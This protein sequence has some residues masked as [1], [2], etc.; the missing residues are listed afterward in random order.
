MQTIRNTHTQNVILHIG[1][2]HTA[3]AVN[4]QRPGECVERQKWKKKKREKKK[5][6]TTEPHPALIQL[7]NEKQREP[8]KKKKSM[9]RGGQRSQDTENKDY[10]N[11][12]GWIKEQRDS[13]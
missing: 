8:K 11:T 3:H 12:R 5:L 2:S 1:H 7:K 9:S 4:T 10:K 6:L 13:K